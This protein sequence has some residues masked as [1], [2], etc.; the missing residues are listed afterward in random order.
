MVMQKSQSKK[1]TSPK[2]K[3][4]GKPQSLEKQPIKGLQD[5]VVIG[6][7]YAR[8]IEKHGS[9][10]DYVA[11][12]KRTAQKVTISRLDTALCE[13]FNVYSIAHLAYI[14]YLLPDFVDLA[15]PAKIIA[16]TNN[17]Y[18]LAKM[19]EDVRHDAESYVDKNTVINDSFHGLKESDLERWGD[20]NWNI[21]KKWFYAD[22]IALDVKVEALTA[23]NGIE[24]S[25]DD[26]LD[27]V[28]SYKP[29]GYINPRKQL[30]NEIE[31]KFKEICGFSIK[32]YYSEHLIKSCE[33]LTLKIE[34]QNV[35]F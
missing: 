34:T 28:K 24:I 14:D 30:L 1:A 26:V 32:P 11:F 15:D 29:G 22:A 31:S 2:S 12:A 6:A 23:E 3:K 17:P 35:P 16:A 5:G 8:H 13:K 10:V 4:S 9:E 19:W 21:S 25:I 20:K 7:N 33:F 18:E 27:F